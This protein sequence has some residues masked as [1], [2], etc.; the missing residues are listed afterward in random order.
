MTWRDWRTW[1]A[2]IASLAVLIGLT[3]AGT[4]PAFAGIDGRDPWI[5][6]HCGIDTVGSGKTAVAVPV[7]RLSLNFESIDHDPAG[8]KITVV[9]TIPGTGKYGTLFGQYDPA[10][11]NAVF[12]YTIDYPPADS[13]L[14]IS[15]EIAWPDG[16]YYSNTLTRPLLHCTR[17]NPG[18]VDKRWWQD[19]APVTVFQQCTTVGTWPFTVRAVDV[20][21]HRSHDEPVSAGVPVWTDYWIPGKKSYTSGA[22]G[23]TDSTGDAWQTFRLVAPPTGA[24]LD[25]LS[26]LRDT[27]SSPYS[28]P[29]HTW[30]PIAC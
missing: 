19:P 21:V 11:A 1:R 20:T 28:F 14:S 25:I 24:E 27:S 8:S 7:D 2:L 23:P 6:Q 26:T 3:A 12:N 22:S 5:D 15:F 29:V 13:T 17:D 4:S 9:Y 16:T 10:R 18:D 30:V